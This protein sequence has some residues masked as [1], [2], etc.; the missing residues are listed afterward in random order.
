MTLRNA[1]IALAAIIATS[2]TSFVDSASAQR[3]RA[4]HNPRSDGSADASI[5]SDGGDGVLLRALNQTAALQI[6]PAQNVL[7][8]IASCATPALPQW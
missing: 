5:V 7:A 4:Q 6:S 1:T 8:A 3:Q 2:A